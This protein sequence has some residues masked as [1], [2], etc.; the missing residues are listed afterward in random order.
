MNE[1]AANPNAKAVGIP[2]SRRVADAL[3]YARAW[4]DTY[5]CSITSIT[6][7]HAARTLR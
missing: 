7:F 5:R 3:T 4:D 2:P 1:M 6:Q